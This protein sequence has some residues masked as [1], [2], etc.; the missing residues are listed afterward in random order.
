MSVLEVQDLKM[1]YS[2]PSG[3]VRAVDNLNFSIEKGVGLGLAGES[4]CGKSSVAITLLKILPSNAHIIGG[5]VNF[6][7]KDILSL[8]EN[9]LRKEIRWKGISLVFQGAMNALNPVYK[10]EDQILEAIKLH[11]PG[12]KKEAA[13]QRVK[14]LFELV[15]VDPSRSGNYPH[16]FSGGMRQRACIAMALACNP[17]LLIADEPSTALDV[18]VAAQT[19]KLLKELKSKLNLAM[20]I[21]SHDLS[22]I[23]E[24]CEKVAIMYAGTMAEYGDI[25]SIFKEP[26][27]PY[28]QDLIS[29]FPSIY[30][31]RV[32]LSYIPGSPPDLLRPPKGC[33]FHPRCKYA[34]EICRKERPLLLETKANH[35]VSCHLVNKQ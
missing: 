26:M 22:I 19:L 13:L 33:R 3:Y 20:L 12:T 28:T 23:A 17:K 7:G 30:S 24:T 15:G 25:V 2:L 4:G 16:E 34:M 5:K 1:Y 31:Q 11:E 9:T 8:N 10:V 21:I 6:Q 32:K 27:H 29:A 35:Y 14:K 18:I